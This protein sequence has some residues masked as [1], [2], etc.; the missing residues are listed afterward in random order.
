MTMLEESGSH[1][2]LGDRTMDSVIHNHQE[3]Q[4]QVEAKLSD[5]TADQQSKDLKMIELLN[6]HS[7]EAHSRNDRLE[8][9]LIRLD[10]WKKK[11]NKYSDRKPFLEWQNRN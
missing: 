9:K 7:T 11:G 6:T 2:Q 5:L 8:D 10:G 4:T 3:W 1:S